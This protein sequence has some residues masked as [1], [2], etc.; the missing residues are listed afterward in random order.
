MLFAQILQQR[1]ARLQLVVVGQPFDKVV[2]DS[3]RLVTT[4][5]VFGEGDA[6]RTGCV[7]IVGRDAMEEQLGLSKQVVRR[8]HVDE[9]D[10]FDLP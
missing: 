9:R 7:R 3:L 10:V 4:S 8:K 2:G 6:L 1:D 5:D